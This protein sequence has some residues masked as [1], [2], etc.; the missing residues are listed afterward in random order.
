MKIPDILRNRWIT[1]TTVIS[2]VATAGGFVVGY[3][4]GLRRF[5]KEFVVTSIETT[6]EER[7]VTTIELIPK[8]DPDLQALLDEEDQIEREALENASQ[9]SKVTDVVESEPVRVFAVPDDDW[10]EEME[11]SNRHPNAPYTIHQDEYISDEMG[12]HQE[13]VTYYQGDDILADV[14]DHPIYNYAGLMGELRFG[15][16]SK[17]P[18]TVYIRNETLH[19][20]WE[21]LLHQGSF[22]QE[23]IGLQMEGEAEDDLQH[24]VQKFRRD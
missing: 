17:D 19:I 21:V 11:L 1:Q 22:E 18:G 6:V 23:V 10:D 7:T 3:I 5:N 8:T 16:G 15:H 24:S 20:E 14:E 13:T 4:Q 12:F 9:P 2:A